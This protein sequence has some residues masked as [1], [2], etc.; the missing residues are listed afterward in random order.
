[1]SGIPWA[2][3]V[4]ALHALVVILVLA[5][6][7][8]AW[9]W[10]AVRRVHLPVLAATVAVNLT[11]SRCPLTVLELRLRAAEGRE[12]YRGGFVGHYVVEPLLGAGFGTGVAVGATPAVSGLV[13]AAAVLPNAVA[14]GVPALRWARGRRP[15]LSWSRPS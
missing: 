14:Y 13:C 7:F 12:P 1:M 9:R 4:A 15:V 5:G 2:D 8:V 3:G 11:G 6:G 10:P